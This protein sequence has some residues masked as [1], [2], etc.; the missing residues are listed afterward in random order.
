MEIVVTLNEF[1]AL[2]GAVGTTLIGVGTCWNLFLSR[3]GIAVSTR[4][5]VALSAVQAKQEQNKTA[6]TSQIDGVTHA[7]KNG[8]GANIVTAT[9]E[10]IKPALEEAG[11]VITDQVTTQ[12]AQTAEKVATALVEKTKAWDGAER[13]VGPADRRGQ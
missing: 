13:R 4:N 5:E 8:L 3:K 9:I 10:Q 12:V 1:S 2:L 6:L 7:I 11:K